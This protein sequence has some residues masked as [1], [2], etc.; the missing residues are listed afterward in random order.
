MLLCLSYLLFRRQYTNFALFPRY[1]MHRSFRRT[2]SSSHFLFPLL[3]RT[4]KLQEQSLGNGFKTETIGFIRGH[5]K[6]PLSELEPCVLCH[7]A[8]RKHFAP[9]TGAWL[10]L[11]PLEYACSFYKAES[12]CELSKFLNYRC[13]ELNVYELRAE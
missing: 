9:L 7:V 10:F 4:I 5:N 1:R 2:Y 12:V 3:L 11:I 13:I 6:I 8:I